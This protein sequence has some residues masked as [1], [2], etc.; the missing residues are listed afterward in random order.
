MTKEY[1]QE[2]LQSN[3][4]WIERGLVVLY[5]RQTQD[6][7]ENVIYIKN[8]DI[9]NMI[10]THWVRGTYG[11]QYKPVLVSDSTFTNLSKKIN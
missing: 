11:D 5:N 7:K 9:G 10:Y 3:P 2:Q 8:T 1:I 4:K 6:E